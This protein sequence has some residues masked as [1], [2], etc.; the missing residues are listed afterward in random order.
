MILIASSLSS[1]ASRSSPHVTAARKLS[2]ST[3]HQL[4]PRPLVGPE[5][6]VADFL[7]NTCEMFGVAAS[8]GVR[9][10]ALPQALER[11]LPQGLERA[12][13]R[14]AVGRRFV[15]EH[16]LVDQGRD[17]V[18]DVPDFDA[19]RADD[20]LRGRGVEGARE[21]PEAIEHDPLRLSEQ[22]VRPVD[23]RPERL[24]SLD[25]GTPPSREQPEPLA[26]ARGDVR[27]SHGR[28]ARRREL[29]GERNPVETT[30]DLRD[31]HDVRSFDHRARY[32]PSPPD[33]RRGAAA[34]ISGGRR[35]RSA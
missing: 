20:R 26:K 19:V 23:G 18:D 5:H 3:S 2:S 15:V 32:G 34:S 24:V 29:D 22:G 8:P 31:R 33:P 21:H 17:P 6:V 4:A 1:G 30:A 14:G 35:R 7:C 9:I 27:W 12:V 11:V 16:R 13:A 28:H 25:R 10:A